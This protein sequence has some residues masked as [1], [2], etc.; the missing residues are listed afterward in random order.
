MA[1]SAQQFAVNTDN[2]SPV[3]ANPYDSGS[4][5]WNGFGDFFTAGWLSSQRDKTNRANDAYNAKIANELEEARL[6]SAR[7]YEMYMDSTKYQRAVE[8][9]KKA[10]LNPLLM[11]GNSLNTS[12]GASAGAV[13]SHSPATQ[14]KKENSSSSIVSSALKLLAILALK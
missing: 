13:A 4:E 8:D 2:Y 14:K 10:G 3:T 6:Q 1:S 5:F 11:F 9:I 7:K 12:A